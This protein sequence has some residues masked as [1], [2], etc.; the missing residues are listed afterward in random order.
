MLEIDDLREIKRNVT[1]KDSRDAKAF[2]KD[3]SADVGYYALYLS[4]KRLGLADGE[5]DDF[6]SLVR[7]EDMASL[8]KD[9]QDPTPAATES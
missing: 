5:L 2:G 9:R 1:V 6:L 7:I 8:T 4:A 3:N